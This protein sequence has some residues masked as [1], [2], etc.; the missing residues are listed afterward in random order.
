MH[1]MK[2][3]V[4]FQKQ[5]RNEDGTI[6]VEDPKDVPV[7]FNMAQVVHFEGSALHAEGTFICTALGEQLHV[8]ESVQYISEKLVVS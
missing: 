7:V 3:T 6:T 4:I 1:F 5:T 8:R 2:L